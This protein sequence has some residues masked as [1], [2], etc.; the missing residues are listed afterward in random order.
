MSVEF[1]CVFGIS[2]PVAGLVAGEQV[3]ALLKGSTI[4]TIHGKNGRVYWFVIQKLDQKYTYPNSPRFKAT[5]IAPALHPLRE[6]Q[7]TPTVTFQMVWENAITVSM[8]AL[9]ENI[10]QKW[11]YGRMVL[12][13]DSAH[14]VRTIAVIGSNPKKIQIESD[15]HQKMTPN[16][17]QGA[18]MAIED[19]ATLA[20]M[21]KRRLDTAGHGLSSIPT[22]SEIHHLLRQYQAIRYDR[23]NA[24]YQ[25]SRFLVRFQALDGPLKTM[26]VRYYA[27]Y[28]GDL[29]ADMASKTI[30]GGSVCE[31]HPF[32]VR[33]GPGWEKYAARHSWISA[34]VTRNLLLCLIVLVALM[35]FGRKSWEQRNL[36][37][38]NG[39]WLQDYTD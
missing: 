16:V 38:G 23:V 5:D 20:N 2:S 30:A 10:F 18:N 39:N 7:L 26:F 27:P 25:S 11:H 17:G 37:G 6:V 9:E 35:F 1:S 29:P 14:K 24:I 33:C 32:P 12:I 3:N 13:G 34:R 28:A 22:K 31:F 15:S 8:T 36:A 21:L 4:V 19:A